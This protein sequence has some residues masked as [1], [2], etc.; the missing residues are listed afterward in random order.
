MVAMQEQLFDCSALSRHIY[1]KQL[2]KEGLSADLYQRHFRST[3]LQTSNKTSSGKVI[4]D[5]PPS[6]KVSCNGVVLFQVIR[7]VVDKLCETQ[8]RGH[9]LQ[10]HDAE[11]SA[12]V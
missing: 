3:V 11:L 7:K 5:R 12:N 6:D 9:V 1:S 2:V 10:K 8:P 4:A